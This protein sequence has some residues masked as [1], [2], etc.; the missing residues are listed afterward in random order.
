MCA[1]RET[2]YY[3]DCNGNYKFIAQ[4]SSIRVSWELQTLQ[5]AEEN[6]LQKVESLYN[7]LGLENKN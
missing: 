3:M 4:G 6:I 1:F 5:S 7:I 2:P